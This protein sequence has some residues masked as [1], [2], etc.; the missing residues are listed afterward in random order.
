MS[1]KENSITKIHLEKKEHRI[2]QKK[3][4]GAN[5]IP[6]LSQYQI[7]GTTYVLKPETTVRMLTAL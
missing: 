4:K 2:E 7:H 5:R 3:P 6:A 1:K